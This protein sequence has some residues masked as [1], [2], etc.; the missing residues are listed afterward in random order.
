MNKNVIRAME[1]QN[2]QEE[3]NKSTNREKRRN[4]AIQKIMESQA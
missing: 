1:E 4:E 3:I 2:I